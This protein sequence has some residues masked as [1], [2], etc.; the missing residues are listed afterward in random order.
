MSDRL[1]DLTQHGGGPE[2]VT[3][4]IA[5]VVDIAAGAVRAALPRE[6]WVRG[7]ISD[8]KNDRGRGGSLY[9]AL[10]DT[11]EGRGRFRLPVT[12]FPSN[13]AKV[14][15]RLRE[16][17][18]TVRMSDG[19]DVRLRGRIEV[20]PPRSTVQLVM[21]DID[22]SHTLGTL[23]ISR[24]AL[25]QSLAAEGLLEANGRCPLSPSPQ[26]IGLVTSA[27]SAACKDFLQELQGS[28]LAWTVLLADTRVQGATAERS[29][30]RAVSRL[31]THNVDAIAVVRGGGART[32]LASFDAEAVARAIATCG[33][34]VLTGIGHEIDDSVADTVAHSALKT[35]TACAGALIDRV[36]GFLGSAEQTY[37]S[38]TQLSDLAVER[39]THRLEQLAGRTTAAASVAATREHQ[40][41]T[42]YEWS[43]R[44]LTEA[45]VMADHHR[46]D[47]L[48]RR[49]GPAATRALRDTD[50][51]LEHIDARIR[52]LDP[53]WLLSRGWSITRNASGEVVRG[54]GDATAGDLVSIEVADGRIDA[55]VEPT[56]ASTA[57]ND[58]GAS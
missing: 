4:S 46:L 35:P 10:V 39:Q 21:S 9:F 41:L 53:Q 11:E 42:S 6:V 48:A 7:E 55:V 3:H 13:R 34:P 31:A 19:L 23:A 29:I 52:A 22:P 16:A 44:S 36:L 15:R 37:R 57:A 40:R 14:N 20:Y 8:L 51:T 1:F 2:S 27:K 58:P 26:R 38:I 24:D 54:V 56:Q 28:G 25:L 12:L 49:L 17:G 18:G 5:E 47:N 30:A 33:V 43:L 50:R 45:K 32:D